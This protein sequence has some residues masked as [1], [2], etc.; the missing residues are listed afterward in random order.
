M[1]GWTAF[2]LLL[3]VVLV[4]GATVIGVGAYQ[5]GFAAGVA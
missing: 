5:A 3:I 2:C 1:N 4:L